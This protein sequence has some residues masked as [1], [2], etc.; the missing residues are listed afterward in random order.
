MEIINKNITKNFDIKKTIQAGIVLSGPEVKSCKTGEVSFKGAYCGFIDN[1]LYL[2]NFY[3]APYKPAK[4]AQLDYNPYQPRK[5]L[6]S[7]KELRFLQGKVGE[8][9]ITIL[10]NRIYTK[11]RLVKIEVAVAQGLKKH[12]KREKIKKKEFARRFGKLTR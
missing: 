7:R 5:L 12:D 10:P 8:K 6:L 9:G 11:S 2:K 3:I 4:G 1:N